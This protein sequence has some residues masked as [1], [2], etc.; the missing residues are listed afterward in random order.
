MQRTMK[1]TLV[2]DLSVRFFFYIS[3]YRHKK[4]LQITYPE[5][6]RFYCPL[7]AFGYCNGDH[8]GTEGQYP[9]QMRDVAKA[10]SVLDI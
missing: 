10:F 7:H 4:Y 3:F 8:T 2:P 6:N 9:A 1:S 5:N